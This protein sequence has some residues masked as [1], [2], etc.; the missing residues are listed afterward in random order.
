MFDFFQ[1]S[2][3]LY[4]SPRQYHQVVSIG[5]L[6]PSRSCLNHFQ[7]SACEDIFL[8]LMVV[9]EGILDMFSLSNGGEKGKKLMVSGPL[10]PVL[11]LMIHMH[12]QWE[13]SVLHT[14][15]HHDTWED[16]AQRPVMGTVFYFCVTCSITA[17]V[18]AQTLHDLPDVNIPLCHIQ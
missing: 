14:N 15:G 9:G 16:D 1:F 2:Y 17:T 3:S 11:S 10:T 4:P 7:I 8:L 12:R 5:F 13:S 18:A 6:L